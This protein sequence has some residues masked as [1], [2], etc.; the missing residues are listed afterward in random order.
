VRPDL[1]DV[2]AA[3]RSEAELTGMPLTPVNRTGPAVPSF[4]R[5]QPVRIVEGSIEGGYTN[6]W[7][8]I[9]C[10]CGETTPV[11]TT[12]RSRP[13]FSGSAGRTR[14]ARASQFMRSTGPR[15]T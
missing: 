3:L 11:W 13:Y 10:G 15:T 8:V 14:C 9:C 5:R 2:E 12:P 4:L 1:T 6:V 7:E